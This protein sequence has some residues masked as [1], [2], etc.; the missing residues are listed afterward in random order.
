MRKILFVIPIFTL[1]IAVAHEPAFSQCA[2]CKGAAETSMQE[3]S[4]AASGLNAGVLYLF[5]SPFLL[6]L[7]I[8]GLWYWNY[9]KNKKLAEHRSHMLDE[10]SDLS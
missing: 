5:M 4:Q 6:V 7:T 10:V 2:M 8:S 3:G 9:R 1:L